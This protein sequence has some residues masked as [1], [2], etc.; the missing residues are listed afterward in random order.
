MT[1]VEQV[2]TA[3]TDALSTLPDARVNEQNILAAADVLR[4]M[5][6]RWAHLSPGE[7]LVVDWPEKPRHR[8]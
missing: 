6:R 5:A 7:E 4:D 1:T 8:R 3:A 2:R